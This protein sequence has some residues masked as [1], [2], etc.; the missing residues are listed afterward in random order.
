MIIHT[1]TLASG[2]ELKT[3]DVNAPQF[4]FSFVVVL[5]IMAIYF[6]LPAYDK[7]LC[8]VTCV[9]ISIDISITVTPHTEITSNTF[10]LI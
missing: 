2:L 9:L 4:I 6:F 8:D 7:C 1:H 3:V 5:L 10:T